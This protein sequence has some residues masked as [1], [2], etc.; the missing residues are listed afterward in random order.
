[1]IMAYTHSSELRTFS[2]IFFFAIAA[3]GFILKKVSKNNFAA[4]WNIEH[5]ALHIRS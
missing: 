5:F 3:Y 2:I 1:M 4:F